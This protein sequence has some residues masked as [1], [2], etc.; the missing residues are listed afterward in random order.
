M[1]T[2]QNSSSMNEIAKLTKKDQRGGVLDLIQSHFKKG[3][4]LYND[5]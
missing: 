2:F 3:D 4:F 1:V 5:S